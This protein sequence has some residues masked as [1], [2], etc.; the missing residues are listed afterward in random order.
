MSISNNIEKWLN[1]HDSFKR[2]KKFC[3]DEKEA[4]DSYFK[5]RKDKSEVRKHKRNLEK[6]NRRNRAVYDKLNKSY[7]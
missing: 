4:L 6:V 2:F 1:K 7:E 3:N 5:Y